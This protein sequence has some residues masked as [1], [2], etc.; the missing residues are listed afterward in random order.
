MFYFSANIGVGTA[1]AQEN[2]FSILSQKNPETELLF[3]YVEHACFL[4][5]LLF[6]VLFLKYPYEEKE[7]STDNLLPPPNSLI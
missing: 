1:N 7:K 2:N 5:L 6:S 3:C 4:S